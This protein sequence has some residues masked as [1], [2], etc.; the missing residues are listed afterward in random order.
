MENNKHNQKEDLIE[1]AFLALNKMEVPSGPSAVTVATVLARLTTAE[2]E[3]GTFSL[4]ERIR[5]M[6]RSTKVAT[7]AAACVVAG[8]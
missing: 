6:K 7:A 3:P 2:N 8:L 1:R 4:I 5:N